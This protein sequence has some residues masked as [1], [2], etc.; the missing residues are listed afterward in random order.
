MPE[1][2]PKPAWVSTNLYSETSDSGPSQKWILYYKPLYSV[3]F[4]VPENS[5]FLLI[6][7]EPLKRGTTSLQGTK[8]VNLHCHYVL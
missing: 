6:Q 8:H 5:V 4:I 3:Q 7:F 2:P 1:R